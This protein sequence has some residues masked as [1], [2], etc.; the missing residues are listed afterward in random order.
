MAPTCARPRSRG[1][2]NA[3][4]FLIESPSQF[5]SNG[6]NA[7]T[8]RAYEK[9]FDEVKSL[10]AIDS[11]T[12]TADQTAAAVFWQFPPIALWNRPRP[13]PARERFGLDTADQ[14]RL[15]A[16]VNLAAADGAISCWN[17]K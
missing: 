10:G 11:T 14:A 17:D 6:P 16:I 9:D 13:R 15:Y 7:L 5:R 1:S 3:K 12:R 2:A 8:S 4:P